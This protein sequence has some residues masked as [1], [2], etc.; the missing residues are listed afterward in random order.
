MNACYKIMQQKVSVLQLDAV[1]IW[2]ERQR[3]KREKIYIKTR[4]K[5]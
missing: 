1:S 3:E 5:L 4:I 2:V